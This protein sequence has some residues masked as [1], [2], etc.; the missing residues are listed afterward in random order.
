MLN[1]DYD[2]GLGTVYER[3]MLNKMFDELVTYYNIKNVLE[4]P[5]FGMTGL[6]G[7]NSIQFARLGCN[8]TLADKSPSIIKATQLWNTL[9]LP[10]NFVEVDNFDSIPLENRT[11]DLVWNF[12]ALW[13]TKHSPTVVHEMIRM[14][15]NLVL[16]FVQNKT[17]PGYLL[18]KCFG[19]IPKGINEEWLN[20]SLYEKILKQNK[21]NILQKGLIDV[22][23]FPDVAIPIGRRVSKEWKWNIMDYYFGKDDDLYKRLDKYTLLERSQIPFKSFWAHHRFILA[24]RS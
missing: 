12:A 3:M 7:I 14:S 18:R 6:T 5:I 23:P 24:Q 17:Q 11:F 21:F 2:E 8:V 10:L 1:N 13:H 20:I 19:G 15:K 4:T 22:P 16:I 9:S